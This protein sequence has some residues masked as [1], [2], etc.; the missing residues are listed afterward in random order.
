M[1]SEAIERMG[2]E[3][4]INE[5]VMDPRLEQIFSIQMEAVIALDEKHR[6]PSWC[7]TCNDIHQMERLDVAISAIKKLRQKFGR[8]RGMD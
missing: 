7:G 6:Y 5:S 8:K 2:D 4:A 3:P 1:V